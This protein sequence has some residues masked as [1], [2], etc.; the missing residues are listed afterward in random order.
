MS[1]EVTKESIEMPETLTLSQVMQ[2]RS[3]AKSMDFN[4]ALATAGGGEGA[5][6]DMDLFHK[7]IAAH[8][9]AERLNSTI[10]IDQVADNISLSLQESQT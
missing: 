5:K 2:L 7:M 8:E 3:T 9:E 4:E 1:N 6:V 10:V